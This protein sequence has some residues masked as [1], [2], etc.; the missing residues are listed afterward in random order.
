MEHTWS[1]F[2]SDVLTE[3]WYGWAGFEKVYKVRRGP[4][5]DRKVNSRFDDGLLGWRGFFIRSQETLM[6]WEWDEDDNTVGWWQQ[7]SAGERIFL[8]GEK[9]IHFRL[10][11]N[12]GS[13]EGHALALDTPIPTPDGW[14][15]MSDLQPGAKVF[16]E[17]GRIRYVT[18]RKDWKNRPCYRVNFNDGTSIVADANHQWMTSS[19]FERDHRTGQS[20]RTTEE[21]SKSVKV[22]GVSNH[23]IPWA[24]PLD[25]PEQCLPIHPYFFGLWLGDGTSLT[26]GISCHVDDAD[27]TRAYI[28]ACGYKTDI[29]SNGPEGGMG[30]LISVYGDSRWDS[31][32]PAHQL[33]VLG[34]KG[35]KHIPAVYMRGSIEQRKELLRGLMDS[36][37]YVDAF[38][39]CEFCNVNKGISLGVAE[40]VRSLGED[41]RVTAKLRDNDRH[42]TAWLVKFTPTS[43]MF[44]LRRK[45]A[46]I[47]DI[48]T[49]QWHYIVSVERVEDRDTACIEVD[50]PSHLFL[51]GTGMVPTH[52][53]LLRNIYRSWFFLKRLQELEAI[54][55][56]RD[57]TGVPLI[58]LPLK[59]WQEAA[60]IT[61]RATFERQVQLLRR[62]EHEGVV[63]PAS[64]DRE[65]KPTG[66]DIGLMGGGARQ[67]T[68][69][70][71]AIRGY[72][73]E[74][75]IN[76]NTQFQQLG[77]DGVGSNALSSDQTN[78]FTIGLGAI[79]CSIR[80]TLNRD[81]VN[82]L[83]ELN[84]FKVDDRA[85]VDHGD[86]EKQDMVRFSSAMKTL[87]DASL[88]TPDAPLEAYVREQ[89]Q[90]P[91]Q[92][93]AGI[94]ALDARAA[95]MENAIAADLAGQKP[96]PAKPKEGDQAAAE[97][98]VP[99]AKIDA[100]LGREG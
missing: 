29:K 81:P 76:F 18:A 50:G 26:S 63:F 70:R 69:D 65:G 34:V 39:R 91:K 99:L 83:Q 22:K 43:G 47:K 10:R 60:F 100:W 90:L 75:G 17:K 28:E 71:E 13:P 57:N 7:S 6:E 95:A 5:P 88:L 68:A 67:H 9:M 73:R 93:E 32:G 79:L 20:L 41:A 51:A 1:D 80:D 98:K 74:I 77:T 49:R 64:T 31:S 36:D 86:I 48:R 35:N 72:Q 96:S 85:Q 33:R 19:K 59:Y 46:K 89:M 45:L 66:F 87:V 2:I 4:N 16:D 40:L 82:E 62:N 11:S 54:G 61:Q 25:Y 30:R 15:L 78:Q 37:G 14:R 92:D 8:P 42:N 97:E 21:L 53:S 3:L 56:E 44:K 84:G 27:E 38:G 24:A 23:A 94:G 52:N 12:R 58:R 55:I